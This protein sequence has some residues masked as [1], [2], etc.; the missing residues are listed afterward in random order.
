MIFFIW[1]KRHIPLLNTVILLSSGA[2]LTWAHHAILINK[3]SQRKIAL[4]RTSILGLYFTILQGFEYLEAPFSLNDSVY[5]SCFFVATGFHGLHV[6]IGTTFLII[7]FFRLLKLHFSL[8]HHFGFEARAWYWHFVDVIW[9]LLYSSI[10]LWGL[11]FVSI[12]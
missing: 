12:I 11:Y 3:I 5:G 2:S 6:I 10:Y 9:L 1:I 7:C 4:G 8:Y